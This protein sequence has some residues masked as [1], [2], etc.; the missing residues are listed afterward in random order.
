MTEERMS[1]H[2]V[3]FPNESDQ[4]VRRDGPIRHFWN[5]EMLFA[6]TDEGEDARHVDMIWPLWNMFDMTPDGRGT[7]WYPRLTY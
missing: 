7:N 3:R 4:Y 5:S 6:T 1:H 2:T